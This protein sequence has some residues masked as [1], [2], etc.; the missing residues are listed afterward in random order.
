MVF[1]NSTL[2]SCNK[3]RKSI[4]F[5]RAQVKVFQES[6]AERPEFKLTGA[7][8]WTNEEDNIGWTGMEVKSGNSRY[9][10]ISLK[11]F[12]KPKSE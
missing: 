10:V 3:G 6:G 7:M 4:W 5:Y 1:S 11:E 9:N 8:C 2:H 12:M